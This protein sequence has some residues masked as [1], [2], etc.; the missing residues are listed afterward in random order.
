MAKRLSSSNKKG[1][2][3][4]ARKH[5][6]STYRSGLEETTAAQLDDTGV[7]YTFESMKIPYTVPSSN[8]TYT[9][10]FIITTK[11]GKSLIVETKGIW[12][13]E[14]RVKHYLIRNQHPD[15]DIRFVFTRSKSTISKGSKTTYADVCEGKGRGLFKGMVWK[16]A[17]KKIPT[18]W[19][20]E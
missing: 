18:E 11:S 10:D 17:D 14:D 20:L 12:T 16:Y 4:K 15:L 13:Y 19:L 7:Q 5:C 2:G 9:P 3:T 6:Q 8:H 1:N